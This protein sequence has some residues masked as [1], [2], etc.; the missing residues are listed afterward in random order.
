MPEHDGKDQG[1]DG[2]KQA[3]C[4]CRFARHRW[5]V[6]T[7]DA[8]LYPPGIYWFAADHYDVLSFSD[9]TFKKKLNAS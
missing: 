4:S 8:D 3:A 9:V 2:A 6:T 1:E 7:G 5:L